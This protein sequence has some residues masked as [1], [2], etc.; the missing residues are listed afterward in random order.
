MR[1]YDETFVLA[2]RAF[3]A[4]VLRMIK[5]FLFEYQGIWVLVAIT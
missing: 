2:Y 3:L 1:P 5:T 4:Q